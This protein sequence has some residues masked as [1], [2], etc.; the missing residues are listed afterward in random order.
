M[1]STAGGTNQTQQNVAAEAAILALSALYPQDKIGVVAF[2]TSAKW[3]VDLQYNKDPKGIASKIGHAARR[4]HR[5]PCRREGRLRSIG[6]GPVGGAIKHMIVIT[7]GHGDLPNNFQLGGQLA[8]AGVTISTIGVGDGHNAAGL[9]NLAST[10]NGQFY[11][12]VN[13]ANLPQVFI[14]EARAIRKNLIKEEPFNPIVRNVASP[15]MVG[16]NAVPPL[17]G[18]VLTGPKSIR[19]FLRRSW[20]E[21]RADLCT[22]GLAWPAA[23]F[24][25]D[26]TNRWALDWLGT[27]AAHPTTPTSGRERSSDRTSRRIHPGRYDQHD[28]RRHDDDPSRRRRRC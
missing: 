11:P 5:Y 28:R 25:A 15:I 26:A 23:A 13:P 8:N 9:R 2:D 14:K 24:T 12:V 27:G 16:I 6:P 7:D 20:S 1:F 18:F 10:G 4:R 19:V 17:R 3:I 22:T 21:G